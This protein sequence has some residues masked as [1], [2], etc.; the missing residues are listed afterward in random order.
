ME[1]GV[2]YVLAT[3]IGN[4]RDLSPRALDILRGVDVIA[5]EDTRVTQKLLASFQILTKTVSVREHNERREAERIITWLREGKSVA[6]V[7]DAGTPAVS[8]PGA[9]LVDAV[10]EAGF[11]VVPIPGC[12]AVVTA[13]SASGFTQNQFLFYGFLPPKSGQRKKALQPLLDAPHALVFYEAPHRIEECLADMSEVFG[14]ER[15][16][17]LARELTKT[18]ETIHRCPLG[19][20]AAWFAADSNQTRGEFVVIIEGAPAIEADASISPEILRVL[21][22][23]LKDLPVKQAA[24][25][26]AEITGA[27]KKQLYDAAL[28]LKAN[29]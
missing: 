15:R 24:G 23:L 12:S 2:L 13:L 28:K 27:N 7:S 4:L 26:A 16:V 6:Q 22:I 14:A 25:L 11:K 10:R 3:P 8:D 29:D 1:E 20:V 21:G 5:A 18:F 9:I 17:L 19:E